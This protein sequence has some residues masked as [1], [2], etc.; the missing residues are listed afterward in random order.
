MKFVFADSLDFVDPA[1]DFIADRNGARR[2]IHRDDQ[3]PHE[4]LDV[5]PYDGILVSRGIVGDVLHNGKYSESQLMRFRREGARL[6][7]PTP[8]LG[9]LDGLVRAKAGLAEPPPQPQP[10]PRPPVVVRND[11]GD[12][13]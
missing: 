9:L 11:A 2:T 8:L 6:D 5:A 1:F 10:P 13:L 7:V 3:F 12:R 4:Y